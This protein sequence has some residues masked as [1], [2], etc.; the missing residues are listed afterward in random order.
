MFRRGD[1][2]KFNGHGLEIFR[3]VSG[4]VA[5]VS[6][7]RTLMYESQ[8][9]APND[10]LRYYTYDVIVSGALFKDIPEELL[11]RIVQNEKNTE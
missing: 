2:L 1:L 4:S 6:S 7:D 3:Y 8:S 11:I 10:P 9:L 5:L